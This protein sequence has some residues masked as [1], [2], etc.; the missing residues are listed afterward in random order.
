MGPTA[1]VSLVTYQAVKGYGPEF[2]NLLSFLSGVI[3]ILMGAFGLGIMIDFISGPVAS[4]FT[5]AVAIIITSS[6]VKDIL[7]ISGG[8]ATFVKM[9]AN[10]LANIHD[11]KLPDL[12]FGMCCIVVS[13]T[14][15][16]IAKIRVGRK[17]DDSDSTSLQS[18]S[19]LTCTQRVINQVFWLIGTSRNCVIV[20][21][22]GFIG[23]YMSR[24]GPPPFKIVGALPPGLPEVGFPSLHVERGNVTYGFFDMVEI[25]GSGIFVTPLIAVVENIAV[26][27]AFLS[28]SISRSAVQSSSGVRTPLVGSYTGK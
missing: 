5:S 21:A 3:Q 15:R 7:G 1:M 27:K 22:S 8:G 10:I 13:L 26:C 18:S 19:Q 2:A 4:G 25:M 14:L 23:Y 6:Q 12:L 11:T 16:E 9:W 20:V 28:G 24:D 17:G